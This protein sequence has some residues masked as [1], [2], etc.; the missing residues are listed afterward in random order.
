MVITKKGI[1][2]NPVISMVG[3]KQIFIP[4]KS[5]QSLEQFPTHVKLITSEKR[6]ILI[7]SDDVTLI[8]NMIKQHQNE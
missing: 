2:V 3:I 7:P 6:E 5:I 4:F 8:Y 1:I